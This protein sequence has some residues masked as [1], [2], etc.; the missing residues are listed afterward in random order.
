[1]INYTG[2]KKRWIEGNPD[3]AHVSTSHVERQNMTMRMHM[4][5]YTRMTNAFSKKLENHMHMVALYTVFIF[6]SCLRPA[7]Y[8]KFYR[9]SLGGAAKEGDAL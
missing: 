5:R 9:R 7:V 1:M 3:R 6:C 4:R 8:G 2:A